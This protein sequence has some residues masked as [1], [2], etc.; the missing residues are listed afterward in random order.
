MHRG[1]T[2]QEQVRNALAHIRTL[3]AE[4][5]SDL[6]HVVQVTILITDPAD[7]AACNEEYVKHFPNGLPARPPSVLL[8]PSFLPR[9]RDGRFD[10]V[11]HP[12]WFDPSAERGL[13]ARLAEALASVGV[14]SLRYDKR[15]CGLSDGTWV[16]ADLFTLIDDARDAIAFLRSRDDLDPTRPRSA[17]RAAR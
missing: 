16:D 17:V 4:A 10:A 15:G 6:E 8:L 12:D 14:A 7:Y 11:G 1:K 2:A 5:G 13:L 3:L 9:D